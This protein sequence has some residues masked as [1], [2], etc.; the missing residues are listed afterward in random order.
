MRIIATFLLLVSSCLAQGDGKSLYDEA[1]NKMTG[2]PQNRSDMRGID[3]MQRASD[4]GYLPATVAMGTI[5]DTG[6]FVGSSPSKASDFYRKAIGQGN[7][8]AEYLLGR[9]YIS[10]VLT[11]GRRESEKWLLASAQS[12]NPYAAY[13]YGTAVYDRDPVE[14]V[15]WFQP[16]AEAGLPYA[17]YLLGKALNIGGR[18]PI[19][20][21]Q[22]YLWLYV[23]RESGVSEA[24]TEL[25]MV[26]TDLGRNVVESMQ[27]DARDLRN[28]VRRA[29]QPTQCKGWSGELNALP[30]VPPL[31]LLSYCVE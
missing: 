31:E 15:K 18:I 28:K 20:K 2:P 9:M 29:S 10:G 5:Y 12:G 6:A 16:A 27:S 3:L 30:T 26:E 1:L 23:A 22:A 19:D 14:A 8:F 13:L 21:K 25:S 11:G 17:Q 4:Q 7:H 24:G